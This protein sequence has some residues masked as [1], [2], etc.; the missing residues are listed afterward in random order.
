VNVPDVRRLAALDMWGTRG[1]ERRRRLIRA[2]FVAGVVGCL[3]LGVL[4][5]ATGSGWVRLLG[6]WLVGTGI[7]YVPLAIEAQ[8]LS[9]PGALEDEL[10]GVELRRELRRAGAQQFWIAVPLAIVVFALV[11]RRSDRRRALR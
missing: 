2:E 8:S 1:S 6:I 5:L 4:A 9:R 10:R 3:G 7:N 11:G